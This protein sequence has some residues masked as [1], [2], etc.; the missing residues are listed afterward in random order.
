MFSDDAYSPLIERS[1]RLCVDWM[2]NKMQRFLR[3]H[4]VAKLTTLSESTIKRREK[5]DP[6]F[7]RRLKISPRRIVF[8]ADEVDG[9]MKRKTEDQ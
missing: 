7:I 5:D 9:W 8:D 3:L 6:D 1:I 4:E 2:E